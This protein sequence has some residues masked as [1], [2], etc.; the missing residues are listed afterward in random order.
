MGI[1]K[2]ISKNASVHPMSPPHF[3]QWSQEAEHVFHMHFCQK[4]YTKPETASA[5]VQEERPFL[6]LIVHLTVQSPAKGCGRTSFKHIPFIISRTPGHPIP[7]PRG[8]SLQLSNAPFQQGISVYRKAFKMMTVKSL[9]ATAPSRRY[10][11]SHMQKPSRHR[12]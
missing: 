5:C 2:T 8:H 12:Q 4:N 11:S 6:A 3:I 9:R 10:G 1:R 7:S